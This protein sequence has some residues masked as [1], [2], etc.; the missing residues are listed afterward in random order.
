V[1]ALQNTSQSQDSELS[2]AGQANAV[3][4]KIEVFNDYSP[5]HSAAQSHQDDVKIPAEVRSG[6]EDS[7]LQTVSGVAKEGGAAHK[8]RECLVDRVALRDL[9]VE[10]FQRDYVALNKPLVIATDE[11]EDS[12][13]GG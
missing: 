5:A 13:S 7:G 4:E 10:A 9:S 12:E 3:N 11:T 2:P 1:Y 8:L 6:Y